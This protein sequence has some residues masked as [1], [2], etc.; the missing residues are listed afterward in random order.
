[1]K[2]KVILHGPSTLTVSLPFKWAGQHNIGKG[3]ELNV[4]PEG[5][6]LKVYPGDEKAAT[7]KRKVDFS[8]LD[9][10]SMRIILTVLHKSGYDEL[11]ITFKDPEAVRALQE[12]INSRL[13]GYEIIEQRKNTC[14]VKNVA[15]D[16]LS[17]ADALLRRSF[18]VM[19]S[20]ADNSLAD[21]KAGSYAKLPELLVLEETN[22]K[23]VNYCQR[24][25]NKKPFKDEK[26]VYS[27]MIVWA[28]E[29]LC[30]EIRDFIKKIIEN[31][32]RPSPQILGIYEHAVGLMKDYYE[33][34]YGYSDERF[35][36]IQ[37]KIN[38]LNRS[39]DKAQFSGAEKQLHPHL[40]AL[41][42]KVFGGLGSAVGL[43]H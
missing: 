1:M 22:N 35:M 4:E 36:L 34:C 2:R 8:R 40:S 16:H 38:S 19:L 32:I 43:H 27:Y 25:L 14:V 13:I 28:V 31:N 30:D 21:L 18:L 5:S 11:E 17:E 29:N 33:L 15:G 6:M 10:Q 3:D 39:L 37:K 26:T 41:V 20:M 24:L 23:L 42:K 9:L 12:R 7:K